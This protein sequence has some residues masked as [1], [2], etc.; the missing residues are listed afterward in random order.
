MLRNRSEKRLT[1]CQ[2]LGQEKQEIG[3]AKDIV[4]DSH[5]N[6]GES[7]VY[8]I[9]DLTA[10]L[11]VEWDNSVYTYGASYH[12]HIENSYNERVTFVTVC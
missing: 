3:H 7:F 10:K 6:A 8:W 11:V 4:G 9:S 5:G 2:L 12:C 1:G